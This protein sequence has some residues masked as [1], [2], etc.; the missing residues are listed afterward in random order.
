MSEEKRK[1][2]EKTVEWSF[3]FSTLGSRVREFLNSL[4]GDEE[5]QHSSFS[6]AIEQASSAEVK[7]DFSLGVGTISAL[8]G[9]E[10]LHA[11]VDHVGEMRFTV[12]G[13]A[14]KRVRLGQDKVRGVSS[15]MR[16]GLRAIA[17][18]ED[19]KWEIG[20]TPRIPLKLSVDGGVGPT[21]MDLSTL[22]L[23]DLDMDCGVGTL[24]VA[25]APGKY[26]VEIDGGVGQ[27]QVTVPSGA[28]LEM[29]IDGGVGAVIVTVPSTMAVRLIAKSGLGSITVPAG[30]TRTKGKQEFIENSGTWETPGYELASERTFIRFD[31]GV[32]QFT[33]RTLETV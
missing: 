15:S 26:K 7:I 29:K 27:T 28:A 3:D 12:E 16:Q 25:L 19:L 8:E 13:D 23:E 21:K 1:N 4:A 31:G 14:R 17:D 20:L 9:D 30:M 2:D 24:D 18:R 22:K 33:L 11:E 32:G 5:V 10:L 6:A